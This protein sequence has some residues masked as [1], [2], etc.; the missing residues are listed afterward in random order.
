[1]ETHDTVS[2]DRT[3]RKG[4]EAAP[5]RGPNRIRR[6]PAAG[7]GRDGGEIEPRPLNAQKPVDDTDMDVRNKHQRLNQP[8]KSDEARST[9]LLHYSCAFLQFFYCRHGEAH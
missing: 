8:D 4:P 6:N 3:T 1:M 7:A 2:A 9:G 5:T